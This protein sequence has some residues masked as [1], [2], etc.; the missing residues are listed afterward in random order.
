MMRNAIKRLLAISCVVALLMTTQ[1]ITVLAEDIQAEEEI[2]LSEAGESEEAE[3]SIQESIEEDSVPESVDP[4]PRVNMDV[5]IVEDIVEEEVNQNL[6]DQVVGDGDIRVGPGVTA[7][8]DEATGAVE[9]YSNDGTLD[10]Y[11]S[12]SFSGEIK[13][14]KVASGRVYLPPDSSY[15]FATTGS[16][17]SLDL[18]GFDTSYVVR[19]D[20]MFYGCSSLTSL[21]LSSFDT[22]NVTNMDFM[23]C[24]CSRLESLDLGLFYTPNVASMDYM[25]DSCDSL[26]YLDL[27]TFDTSKVT[28]MT[29]MFFGCSSLTTLDLSSFDT[30]NV[31]SMS[32][33]FNS[34]VNMTSLDLSSFDT[35]Y[36]TDMCGMFASCSSLAFLDLGSFDT[37]HVTDMSGMFSNCASLPTLDLGNISTLN[38]T[39]MDSLFYACSSLTSLDLSGFN[40]S[41]VE[42][43]EHMF[44]GCSNLTSLNL[45][46]FNT[47]NV[48]SMTSM[49]YDCRSLA[50]LDLSSFD[51]SNITSMENT[52][53]GC[54][55]LTS[56]D[57]SGFDTSYVVRMDHM[58]NGCSSLT[59]LDLSSFD[60]SNVESMVAM[61]YGCSGLMSLDLSSFDMSN[62]PLIGGMFYGCSNLQ[63]LK[64]PKNNVENPELP[65]VM[66]D[67]DGKEYT[68]LPTTTKSITLTSSIGMKDISNASVEC[69][70]FS[71]I[72]SGAP[73]TPE[74]TVK[75]DGLTLK[76]DTD[77]TVEYVNNIN[78]GTATIIIRGMGTYTGYRTE[79]FVIN[80]KD[81]SNASVGGVGLA[82]GYSGKAYT[83]ELTVKVDGLTL[84]KDT[85]YMVEY[86]N[87]V[88]VGTATIIIRGIGNYT[89]YR[90]ENFK[91]VEN[92]I[93]EA[94]VEGVEGLFF[95][96]S[97]MPCTPALTVKVDGVTLKKDQDYTVE[98]VNNVNVGTATITIT[99]IGNYAGYRTETF[100]IKPK[101]ISNASVGGVSPFFVYSG[102]PCTPALIVKV[103]GVT[104]KK[105]TDYT[106]KYVNNKNI[107]TAN[108]IIQGIGNYTGYRIE[109]FEIEPKDISNASV[110]GISL[111]YGY[112]GKAYTPALTVK[113]DGVTLK[114]DTDYTV[115]YVNNKNI[116]TANIIIQGIGNYTGYRIKTF[117][118]VDC[119]S[120]LVSGKTYQLI[121]K[122]NSKTAVCSF[123][124]KMVNNTRIYITD[125][126]SSEAMKFK[127]I[128]NADG[129]WKF[130]NAKCELALAVQQNSNE[131]GK[132]LVLY[133]QTT[134]IAQNWKLS[135]KSDN[136]FAIIN[137]VSGLSIAMSD[138]SAVKGTT[139][140][141]AKTASVGLQRFYIAET[142]AISAPY[143]GTKSVRASKDKNFG[144]N[145]ASSSKDDN[146]N[147]NLNTYSNTNAKKF[148]I[149]YS[150]GGYYRLVNVN[151]GL[152]L[153]VKGN[154]S[155]DGANVI[156]S[157]WAAQSGQRWKITKNSDGTVTLT[158]ALG[159][160]L[161]L[162]GNKTANGTNIVAKNASTSSAQK[163]YL[164]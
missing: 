149:M 69:I 108:I 14:I 153:T 17:T 7:T 160:V 80:P 36:V 62:M 119:V 89:G 22:S 128:Q 61:F 12:Y 52:F 65:N 163:W 75:V 13:S 1:G 92:D 34:C 33:M 63:K 130:I 83:P 154:T 49:F 85:D 162:T 11:W 123:S 133:D 101:A 102:M 51:T 135:K 6:Q 118:I 150:G 137:A 132:G 2:I 111:S 87:N 124:G 8:Y 42:N 77:Y 30:T 26:K 50:S 44:Q 145:I 143:D 40:T 21:D 15:I 103:D 99:G 94:Y 147:V 121:P 90:M 27:S 68:Q 134:R 74:L 70:S 114:K 106:V 146:A 41:R 159:T 158:N 136:S 91:I 24:G 78:H 100:E 113:V 64:T 155:A 58:F 117:E 54:S 88:N 37:R 86:V 5:F 126:S 9:F 107:G 53:Y 56:L 95:V 25:F 140:S 84:K 59:S 71:Y 141:M 104:L 43:T 20:Y 72:Y 112:S 19:M 105:D 151:S 152:C 18:S 156:Q 16:L 116:G 93:S 38:V 127:A 164:Q 10:Q 82:Y 120:S 96:Y 39:N 125:R 48:T 76:K 32:G 142:S 28:D 23:F 3:E 29:H 60:T 138:E 55:S 31:E 129:T 97:G 67:S 57:L 122:N 4:E 139:L 148:K 35:R 161:H 46:S 131:V 47:L 110:G 66:Y 109:T 115:K 157:K 79:T 73:C 98:Y 144:L 81:I 45:S